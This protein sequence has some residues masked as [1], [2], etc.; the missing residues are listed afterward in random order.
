MILMN[1]KITEILKTARNLLAKQG[2]IQGAYWLDK[3]DNNC[4]HKDACKFCAYGAILAT[5]RKL[6]V[7]GYIYPIEKIF[8]KINNIG[9][10]FWNDAAGR[11]KEEVI[12]A[13]DAAIA[14]STAEGE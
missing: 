6:E 11:R 3:N 1:N 5:C 12:A 13:F 2:W 4:E 9:I 8:Y 14:A 10:I 7:S